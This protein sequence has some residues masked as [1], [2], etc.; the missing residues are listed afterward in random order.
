M[1]RFLNGTRF[2]S[3]CSIITIAVAINAPCCTKST[4]SVSMGS[5]NA[6]A[7]FIPVPAQQIPTAIAAPYRT[8]GLY[9]SARRPTTLGHWL[10]V[11]HSTKPSDITAARRTSSDT[12]DT[13]TCNNLRTAALFPVAT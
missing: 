6:T 10:G 9:D 5:S 1:S 4:G 13:A 11:L 12:S 8:C 2:V 3:D 7:S